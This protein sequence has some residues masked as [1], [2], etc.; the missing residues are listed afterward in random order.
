MKVMKVNLG[1]KIK[2]Y[3]NIS[4]LN[5]EKNFFECKMGIF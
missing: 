3:N 1:E 2:Q 4:S 5:P